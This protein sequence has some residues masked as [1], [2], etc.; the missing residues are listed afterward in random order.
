LKVLTPEP[1]LEGLDA[2]VNG[3]Q[4]VEVDL[5]EALAELAGKRL[6]KPTARSLG[7]LFQ[8][9]LV[10][11]PAWIDDGSGQQTSITP[12]GIGRVDRRV[13]R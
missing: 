3:G 7:K 12:G 5:A 9:R 1:G 2:Q 8:K 6:D 10:G 4:R 11:R 13:V